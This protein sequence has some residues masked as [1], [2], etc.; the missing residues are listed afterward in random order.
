MKTSV[1]QYPE[2]VETES[3][4]QMMTVQ[5][6]ILMKDHTVAQNGDTVEQ[7]TSTVMK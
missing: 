1:L 3:V 7:E 6:K 5:M 2:N 4:Q